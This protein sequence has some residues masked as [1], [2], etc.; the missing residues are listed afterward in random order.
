MKSFAL[1]LLFAHIFAINASNDNDQ[2]TKTPSQGYVVLTDDNYDT[3]V[4]DPSTN[5][6]IGDKLW[7]LFFYTE[8]CG[9]CK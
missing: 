4:V 1:V 7:L 8:N 2:A 9:F 6:I 5:K 3:L